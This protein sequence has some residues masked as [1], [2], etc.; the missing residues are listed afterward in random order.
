MFGYQT[1][2]VNDHFIVGSYVDGRGWK[3]VDRYLL[4]SGKRASHH[5]FPPPK[6]PCDYSVAD[7]P[8]LPLCK[9]CDG[10]LKANDG[11]DKCWMCQL[12]ERVDR[13]IEGESM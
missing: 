4:T 1:I 7:V 12:D 3:I 11:T 6:M 8:S 5:E 2:E 13:A 9:G 10:L